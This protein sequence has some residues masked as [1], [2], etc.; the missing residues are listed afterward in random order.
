MQPYFPPASRKHAQFDVQVS[1]EDYQ[2]LPVVLQ[3]FPVFVEILYTPG[4]AAGLA[5]GLSFKV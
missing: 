4:C 2:N 3:I 5:I 1:A